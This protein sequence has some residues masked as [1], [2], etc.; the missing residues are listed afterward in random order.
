MSNWRKEAE[1]ALD[2]WATFN[3]DITSWE[4]RLASSLRVALEEID[5]LTEH[6]DAAEACA[7]HHLA[8]RLKAEA[9]LKQVPEMVEGAYREGEDHERMMHDA[10]VCEDWLSSKSLKSLTAWK[11]EERAKC[12]DTGEIDIDTGNPGDSESAPCPCRKE[13]P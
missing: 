8:Y 2:A 4:Q 5:K 13:K 12:G 10:G 6:V 9:K 1:K 11:K 7:D 3:K